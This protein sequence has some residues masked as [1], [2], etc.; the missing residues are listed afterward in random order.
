MPMFVVVSDP[1]ALPVFERALVEAGDLG[2]T[3]VPEAWGRGRHG[4]H[5]GDRIH[6]GGS[7]VLFMVVPERDVPAVGT[8]LRGVRERDPSTRESKVFLVPA[9]EW[10]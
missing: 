5:A 3:V 4:L 6:P 2:F 10:E 7:S 1:D 8:L 9:T